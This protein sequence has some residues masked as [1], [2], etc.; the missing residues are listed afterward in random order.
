MSS[1]RRP[2]VLVFD[3]NETLSDM[4][5]MADRF[6][7]V[8]A[9]GH[10]SQVWFAA[11]LRDAFALTVAGVMEPFSRLA[12]E[13]LRVSLA[14][15]PLNRRL[16][17]AVQHI[18]D[19]FA[20]LKVHPDVPEGIAALA[21]LGVR[22][23]TLS[24][25]QASVAERLLEGADLERSFE[26]FLSVDGAGIWKP[27]R[28]A[29]AYAL[30]ECNIDPGDAMLVAVHPWDIDGAQRAG[31]ATAWINRGDGHYP[32]YFAQPDLTATSLGHLAEQLREMHLDS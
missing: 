23:A 20:T 31:L 17:D 18:L 3:V 25:G 30:A 12:A 28:G 15:L 4:A 8:G 7:E 13:G 27:A 1:L 9:P 24:N 29:Y 5:P 19:G 26:R 21:D 6:E 22:L 2:S 11:L 16:E 10:L 14:H 32:G